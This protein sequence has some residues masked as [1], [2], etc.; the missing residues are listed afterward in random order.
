LSSLCYL[1]A[2]AFIRADVLDA[3]L[4]FHFSYLLLDGPLRNAYAQRKVCDGD[5]RIIMYEFDDFLDL[6]LPNN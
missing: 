5:C 3:T 2:A 1:P 6:N 4:R